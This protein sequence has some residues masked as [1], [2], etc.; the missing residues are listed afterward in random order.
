MDDGSGHVFPDLRASPRPGMSK[1]RLCVSNY[2]IPLVE[3]GL[4]EKT[5]LV[6]TKFEVSVC[7]K[8]RLRK[9]IVKTLFLPG[10]EK[11]RDFYLGAPMTVFEETSTRD[12]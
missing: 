4:R 9:P 8:N 10:R 12:C 2:G 1:R 7:I 11:G 3:R 6:L 5:P